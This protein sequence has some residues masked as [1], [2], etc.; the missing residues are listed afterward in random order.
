[1]ELTKYKSEWKDRML[2]YSYAAEK[3]KQE[4]DSMAIKLASKNYRYIK[5]VQ[6]RDTAT[7]ELQEL[8]KTLDEAIAHLEFLRT[9]F[10]WSL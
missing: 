10:D 6:A 7:D 9:E 5:H 4:V 1:M 2:D 3:M 8:V